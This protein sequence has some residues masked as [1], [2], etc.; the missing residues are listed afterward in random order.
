MADSLTVDE[1]LDGHVAL[2]VECLDRIYLNGYV[3]NLQ[4]G[5]QVASF[6]TQHRGYP[7]PSPAIMEKMGTSFRRSVTWFADTNHIPIVQFRK[8]DRKID[9]M[10]RHLAAP[11]ASGR[12]GWR[13][14][15]WPRSTR[16][17]SP[18]RGANAPTMARGS[19]SPRPTGGCRAIVRG[20]YRGVSP[21]PACC[22]GDGRLHR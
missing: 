16:T 1:L 9:V 7:I 3:P 10:G 20:V 22:R 4:V 11:A 18:R 21:G 13:R 19:R 12:P 6:M 2:D 5:G 8:G 17:S 15:E 14:S